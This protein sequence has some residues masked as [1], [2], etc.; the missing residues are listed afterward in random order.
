MSERYTAT[1]SEKFNCPRPQTGNWNCYPWPNVAKFNDFFF[2]HIQHRRSQSTNLY[3]T[4]H[5]NIIFNKSI[6]PSTFNIQQINKLTSHLTH[7]YHIQRI[8][9][10]FNKSLSR[11]TFNKSITHST[12]QYH[13]QQINIAFNKSIS[14][15]TN[16]YHV[17]HS[18]N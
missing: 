11:S 9:I 4:K 13:V 17:Q 5:I 15:S 12:N 10:T 6:S 3:N 2:Y 18:T 1:S 8:N 16:Q 7:Q 14:R